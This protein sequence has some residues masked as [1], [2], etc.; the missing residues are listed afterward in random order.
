MKH[1]ETCEISQTAD[2]HKVDELA[3]LVRRLVQSLRKAAP[4]N[5]LADGAL[6]YLKRH[7]LAGTVLRGNSA[8][9]SDDVPAG[10][11]PSKASEAVGTSPS[12]YHP[13][14]V[15]APAAVAVP[16]EREA[17]EAFA[18]EYGTWD[19]KRDDVPQ[20]GIASYTDVAVVIAWHAWLARAELAATPAAGELAP[21]QVGLQEPAL[22]VL[23]E[24]IPASNT[25]WMFLTK[26][27]TQS[28]IA[29]MPE[30]DRKVLTERAQENWAAIRAE[31]GATVPVVLPEPWGYLVEGRIFIGRLL[32]QHV[33]SMVDS[34]GLQPIKLFT[35][36]QLSALLAGVSAPAAQAGFVSAAAYDRLQALCDSQAAHI[37]AAEYTEPVHW[38]AVL[39]PEQV[40][41]QLKASMHAVGFR[42]QQSAESWIAERLDFDGWRYTLEPLYSAPQAQADARDAEIERAI[43]AERERICAAIK[44][45][46]DHCVAQGDY[47]LDSDDCIKVA[48]GEW[49]RPAYEPAIAAQ[50]TQQGGAA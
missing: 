10:M 13:E 2:S 32:P 5:N 24:E 14:N 9:L 50:A 31:V 18:R 12:A 19:I 40:P 34:E 4:G 15:P 8:F 36:Q 46:D 22:V 43:L 27:M 42:D 21:L 37:L 3:M 47:M 23:P 48:R 6:D 41:H 25:L 29:G 28:A 39:D 45:E 49:V 33:S 26:G 44:T 30:H 1:T 20:L 11:K 7:G 17:F 38:R 16:D 35:E